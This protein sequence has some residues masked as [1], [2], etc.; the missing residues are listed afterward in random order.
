MSESKAGTMSKHN[1]ENKIEWKKVNT[2]TVPF[3]LFKNLMQI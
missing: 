2:C 1:K 3:S